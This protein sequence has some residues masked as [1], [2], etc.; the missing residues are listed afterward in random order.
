MVGQLG[1]A[2]TSIPN[3]TNRGRECWLCSDSV[4]TELTDNGVYP[5][6]SYPIIIGRRVLMVN[7]ASL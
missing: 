2:T 4:A 3:Y 5:I 6:I 1:W 7:I